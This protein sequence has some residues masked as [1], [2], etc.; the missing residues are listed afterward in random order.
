MATCRGGKDVVCLALSTCLQ[1]R[2]F[3]SS[4]PSLGWGPGVVAVPS[5]GRLLCSRGA[6]AS[7]SETCAELLAVGVEA[8]GE[9]GSA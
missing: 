7:S 5:A 6:D 1:G 8:W 3:C 2:A 9:E 4:H